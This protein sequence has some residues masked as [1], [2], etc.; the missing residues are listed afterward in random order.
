MYKWLA[1]YFYATS[2]CCAQL[3]T[4]FQGITPHFKVWQVIQTSSMIYAMNLERSSLLT[5]QFPYP[6]NHTLY[7]FVASNNSGMD[8]EFGL[9]LLSTFFMRICR[10]PPVWMIP[11]Y[12]SLTPFVLGFPKL[13]PLLGCYIPT[14]QYTPNT[15]MVCTSRYHA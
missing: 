15:T 7:D 14:A 2:I 8:S 9:S 13:I 4:C 5:A 1:T 3:Q 10:I 11:L 12:P 6:T